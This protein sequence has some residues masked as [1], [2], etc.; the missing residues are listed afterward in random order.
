MTNPE[1][2]VV[3]LAYREGPAIEPFVQKLQDALSEA[4]LNYEIILVSNY[5]PQ[6]ED[7]T[8]ELARK[9]AQADP[10]IL[11]ITNVKNEGEGMGWDAR[12]G[13]DEARGETIAFIDGDGQMPAEDVVA[14]YRKLKEKGLDL[15]KTV[16]V[17][18]HDGW[19][20]KVTSMAYNAFVRMLFPGI[21]AR[22]INGK[23]KIFTREAYRKLNLKSNGWFLD[24]EIMIKAGELGLK[25][26][27]I[28]TIFKS[29]EH[30]ESMVKPGM[31]LAFIGNIVIYRFKSWIR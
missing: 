4:R 26:D 8:P 12:R 11:A 17:E 18:R 22:D 23:P 10:R 19:K 27:A 15:C 28:P 21:Q 13:M 5:K 31:I 30:R 2:S 24:G 1:I 16:R 20:R 14:V 9:L 3:V 25:Y 29:N 7:E 6:L